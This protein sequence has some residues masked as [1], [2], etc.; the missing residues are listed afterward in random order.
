MFFFITQSD[1]HKETEQYQCKFSRKLKF[2]WRKNNDSGISLQNQFAI[3]FLR[4]I[5]IQKFK[6]I[7]LDYIFSLKENNGVGRWEGFS[8][9]QFEKSDE[10]LPEQVA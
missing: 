6:I 8:D 7:Y 9:F 4:S 2:C 5:K 1:S 3:F 10:N